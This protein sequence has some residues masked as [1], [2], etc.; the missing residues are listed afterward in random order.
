MELSTADLTLRTVSMDDVTEVARMWNYR[1]GQISQEDAENAIRQMRGNHE[2]NKPGF[3]HHLCLAVYEK[4]GNS[5]IGWCGLDGKTHGKL[6]IF[7]SIDAQYRKKG[8]ATQCASQLLSYAFDEIQV[9]FV[10]GGCYKSNIPSFRVM[11]KVGM[12]QHAF[13]ENGDPL[14]YIDRDDWNRM[15]N[16]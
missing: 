16:R 8:Y 14:F 13:E 10:N 7:Y 4:N 3:I 2:K 15:N 5:I 9:P 6:H 11:E 12:K 1:K